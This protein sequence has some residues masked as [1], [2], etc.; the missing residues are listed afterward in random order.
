[1]IRKKIQYARML[2]FLLKKK[3]I[4]CIAVGNNFSTLQICLQHFIILYLYK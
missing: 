2:I 4:V 1:M 3:L